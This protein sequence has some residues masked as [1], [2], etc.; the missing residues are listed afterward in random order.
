MRVMDLNEAL[1]VLVGWVG[2]HVDVVVRTEERSPTV[3]AGFGG[4]L[5]RAE[6]TFADLRHYKSWAD[7][8]ESLM[9]VVGED[10]P[11]GPSLF[12]VD[13]ER[14]QRAEWTSAE[15]RELEINLGSVVIQVEPLS[16]GE[17]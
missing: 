2:E 7:K 12:F 6:D 10:G 3:V 4:E 14:F 15:Q 9:F 13:T 5:R 11:S 8:A 16:N 1:A 17:D